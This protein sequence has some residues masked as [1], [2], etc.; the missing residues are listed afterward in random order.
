MSHHE[1]DGLA[2]NT[3]EFNR[4]R[5]RERV[6]AQ[7]R[8]GMKPLRETRVD[9]SAAVLPHERSN[10]GVCAVCGEHAIHTDK[11]ATLLRRRARVE[12]ISPETALRDVVE[13]AR[14]HGYHRENVN[15]VGLVDAFA[16][17]LTS[18]PTS[19]SNRG[20]TSRTSNLRQVGGRH[21]G[22][23]EFQ[24][25]DLSVMFGWDPFQYQITKYVMRHWDK[26][27]VKDLEKAQHF[28]EKYLEEIKT[29]RMMR[30]V[31]A[32]ETR[33]IASIDV[34]KAQRPE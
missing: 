13:F 11:C 10:E 3:T 28:L 16:D 6:A 32:P 29:G 7:V 12:R 18:D 8:E 2:E 5:E 27:G 9:T 19:I 14:Q 20:A 21:Y 25:W 31:P 22:L 24:H 33:I 30:L 15:L 26:D 17:E 1:D 23:R 34:V 4:R